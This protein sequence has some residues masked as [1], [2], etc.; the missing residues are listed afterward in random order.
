MMNRRER[1]HRDSAIRHA[2][3][4][5]TAVTRIAAEYGVSRSSVYAVLRRYRSLG[6]RTITVERLP[7]RLEDFERLGV[8]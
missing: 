8:E 2:Y 1:A 6:D 3:M 4:N 5:G 7:S